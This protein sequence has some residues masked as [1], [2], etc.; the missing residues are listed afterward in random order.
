MS[1]LPEDPYEVLGVGKD[2]DDGR[3]KRAYRKLVLACHPDKITDI[4][5]KFEAQ[6]LFA[7]VQKAYEVLHDGDAR[8]KYDME[9]EARKQRER[10]RARTEKR[11][12]VPED[13][14]RRRVERDIEERNERAQRHFGK[15]AAE[16]V[17]LENEDVARNGV[18]EE[19]PKPKEQNPKPKEEKPKLYSVPP[20][21]L[22][23]RVMNPDHPDAMVDIVAVHGL[24]AIPEI[25]WKD[26][27]S[28]VNWLSDA[29]MLPALTPG[30]RIL[31]FGYD[32]LWLGREPIRTRLP[33]IADKLLL[34]LARERQAHPRR[35]LVFIGHCFGGLVVQRALITA[36]LHPETEAEEGILDATVGAVLLGTPHRGTG[37][38][39]SQSALLAAIAAQSELYPSMEAGVLEAMEAE[40]GGFLGV[41]EDFLKLSTRMRMRIT[42]FFEQ[43]ESNLGK[44]VGRSDIRVRTAIGHLLAR[45][46][47]S[48]NT[49]AQPLAIRRRRD[50]CQARRAPRD[51]A[52]DGPLQ[53]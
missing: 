1:E 52:L 19:N 4:S 49:D 40:G 21:Q 24:G 33:T 6:A 29:H 53:A 51:R 42:C 37:A 13:T 9:A 22:G 17:G 32:S 34:V 50:L 16:P 46:V 39:G 20:A 47:K 38:F 45:R 10:L 5:E 12:K 11:K 15:T 35:P 23:M 30:A 14:E 3:I 36:K 26:S 44:M 43:R 18:E 31:R 7:R 41:S 48:H 27:P 25:T 8:Q 2:A 28:G